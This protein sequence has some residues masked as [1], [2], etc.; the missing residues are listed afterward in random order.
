MKSGTQRDV[1]TLMS[2]AELF[3]IAQRWKQPICQLMKKGV[4]KMWHIQTMEC[5][6]VFATTW[7]NLE[8][9]MLKWKKALTKETY[10][11]WLQL[12]ELPRI[13]KFIETEG[14]VEVPKRLRREG[15]GELVF[16]G[17]RVS[18]LQY[19]KSSMVG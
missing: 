17:Y 6:L 4:N 9:I 7:M 19:G 2:I 15:K 5:Y 8:D 11:V 14:A 1:C 18:V 3:T 13:V 10:T 12:Y 16:N